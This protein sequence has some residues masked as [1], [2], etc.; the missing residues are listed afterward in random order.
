MKIT[1]PGRKVLQSGGQ[2]AAPELGTEVIGKTMAQA[3]KNLVAI[4]NAFNEKMRLAQVA[5]DVSERFTSAVKEYTTWS[6]E[7][8]KTPDSYASFVP[9]F[10]QK[11]KELRTK[12]FKDVTDQDTKTQLD[13][14]LKSFFLNA[15]SNMTSTARK[16]QLFVLKQKAELDQ[17]RMAELAIDAK[18]ENHLKQIMNDHNE[19]IKALV[20]AG[21]YS[22]PG[23][24]SAQRSFNTHVQVG[25]VTRM[26]QNNPVGAEAMLKK[27]KKIPGIEPAKHIQLTRLARSQAAQARAATV[28]RDTQLLNSNISSI[29]HT[30]VPVQGADVAANSLSKSQRKSYDLK[31]KTA[32]QWYDDNKILQSGDIATTNQLIKD[33]TPKAG[34]P[35]HANKSKYVAQLS[36]QAIKLQKEARD[37]PAKFY[38]NHPLVKRSETPGSLAQPFSGTEGGPPVDSTARDNALLTVQAINGIKANKTSLLSKDQSLAMVNSFNNLKADQKT[39]YFTAL[40]EKYGDNYSVVFRDLVKHGKLPVEAQLFGLYANLNT[41][42]R[43]APILA[44]TLAQSKE[45]QAKAKKELS[46]IMKKSINAEVDSQMERYRSTIAGVDAFGAMSTNYQNVKAAMTKMVTFQVARGAG[47]PSTVASNIIRG[48]FNKDDG[49]AYSYVTG[50]VSA[51]GLPGKPVFDTGS[52]DITISANVR[53]PAQFDRVEIMKRMAI[54]SRTHLIKKFNPVV[55]DQVRKNFK[56]DKEAFRF[57]AEAVQKRGIWVTKPDDTGVWLM[58]NRKGFVLN[59]AGER[60]GFDF[61]ESK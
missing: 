28:V 14:R 53:I 7:I 57:Y 32:Q 45:D 37:D 18:D 11:R 10:E 50:W 40:K 36:T 46:P 61:K 51:A 54:N 24:Q 34:D 20:K 3:G 31:L 4:D 42:T 13:L 8:T 9:S 43:L 59:K 33:R 41:G 30:G 19:N 23:G 29:Q 58:D 52:G 26:I 12:Y 1:I 2:L 49:G 5:S 35:Q 17:N 16:S 25:R 48:T 6:S 38:A 15:H 22:V 56:N 39:A 47:D 44:N 55:P 27:N 21:V 60:Y